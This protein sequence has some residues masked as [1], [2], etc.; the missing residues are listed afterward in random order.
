MSDARVRTQLCEY[1]ISLLLREPKPNK[2]CRP[3]YLEKS[4]AFAHLN[5]QQFFRLNRGVQA[6]EKTTLC[7]KHLAN[8]VVVGTFS[9]SGM[10]DAIEELLQIRERRSPPCRLLY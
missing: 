5:L 9:L 3:I 2:G 4:P 6:I 10:L 1:F 8:F 7:K